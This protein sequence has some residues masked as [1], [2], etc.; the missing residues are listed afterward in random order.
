[1]IANA[2]TSRGETSDAVRTAEKK[3]G[4]HPNARQRRLGLCYAIQLCAPVIAATASFAILRTA[5]LI[6]GPRMM[7]TAGGKSFWQ[8]Y[9]WGIMPGNA[10]IAIVTA[11]LAFLWLHPHPARR[12]LLGVGFLVASPLTYIV[13]YVAW[14]YFWRLGVR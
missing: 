1:M 10:I 2:T 7:T 8:I 12:W 5:W 13:C 4:P 3:P 14:E 11:M 9:E 6:G